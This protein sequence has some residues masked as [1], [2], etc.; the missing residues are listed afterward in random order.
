MRHCRNCDNCRKDM[1]CEYLRGFDYY[2]CEVDGHHIEEPFWEK[3]DHYSRDFL[4]PVS[5]ESFLYQLVR[6]VEEKLVR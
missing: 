3:C 1:V 6:K 5:G 2:K 4:N